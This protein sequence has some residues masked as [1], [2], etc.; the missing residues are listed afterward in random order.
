MADLL[1]VADA[2]DRLGDT[3]YRVRRNL[4]LGGFKGTD[5]TTSCPVAHYLH[6]TAVP[7]G[8]PVDVWGDCVA[9]EGD[10]KAIPTTDAVRAFVK[11]HDA[12]QETSDLWPDEGDY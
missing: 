2:L 7:V 3:E 4:L 1:R 8:I 9:V 5:N 10:G 11:R 12:L 6:A